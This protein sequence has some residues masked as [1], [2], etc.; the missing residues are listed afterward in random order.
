MRIG[1]QATQNAAFGFLRENEQTVCEADNKHEVWV[2]EYGIME[3]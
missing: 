3:D 2:C 1:N